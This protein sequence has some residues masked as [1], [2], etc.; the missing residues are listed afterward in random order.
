MPEPFNSNRDLIPDETLVLVGYYKSPEQHKW[1]VKTG[2][3]NFRMGTGSGSLMFDKETVSSKYLLLHTTGDSESGD[4][5]RIVSRGPRVFSKQDLIKK[6]YPSPNH[7]YYLI[8]TIE[9]VTD[10]EFEN[11]KWN[12]KNLKN[13]TSGRASAIPF[14]T[15][16]AELMQNKIK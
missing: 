16:L 13:Y 12:F 6:G 2:L 4:L 3:Y 5:W 7:D 14:T 10:T 11:V 9:P 15:T 8:F 1:I